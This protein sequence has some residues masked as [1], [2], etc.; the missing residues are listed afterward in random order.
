MIHAQVGGGLLLAA[1]IISTFATGLG[2]WSALRQDPTLAWV[3]RRGLYAATAAVAVSSVI[4]VLALVGHDFAIAFVAE[5]TDRATPVAF[6]VAAFYGGQEG[7]LLYWA[8][9]LSLLGSA[10]LASASAASLAVR[11]WAQVVISGILTFFLTVLVLVASPFA[12]FS[13][14]PPD[15]LGLNPLLRDQGMLIHPPFLLAGFASFAIPFSFAIAALLAREPGAGWIALTRKFALLAWGLQTVGLVLGMWWAYHVLGWGGYWG[16]DPVE[17]VALLPWLASTAYIH[18]AQIQE[19][20]GTLRAWNFGLVILSFL[21]AIFGTFVVRSGIIQSVHSFAV[22]SI[23]PWFLGF[24]IVCVAF[25]GLVLLIRL[26]ELRSAQPLEALV[27]REGAFLLNNLLFI[28]IAI[29]VLWGTLLP[30]ISTVGGGQQLV[31]GPPYY[32]RATGPL[33]LALLGLMAIGPMVPWQRADNRWLRS[34]RSQVL[35]AGLVATVVFAAGVR[36]PL[37]LLTAA[38]LGAAGATCL[39]EFYRAARFARR[40]SS[41]WLGSAW[42]LALRN[43]RRYAAYLAHFGL[44]LIAAGIAGSHFGQQERE[45]V[46]SPGQQVT[47]GN[48][49]LTYVKTSSVTLSD[50]DEYTA[51][52]QMGSET[53]RPQHLVY[54][55]GQSGTR[56][57]IRS[58]PLEDL[59]VV[60]SSVNSDG[61]AAFVLF[62]NPLVTWIWAGAAILIYGVWLGS[63]GA[64]PA[65]DVVEKRTLVSSELARAARL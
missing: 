1:L 51:E 65:V 57:A 22:S 23:G 47:I 27:S 49:T 19:R 26:P 53:L 34:L 24:L 48:Y 14:V 55:G 20:R 56:V 33:F 5:H 11:A 52:L 13:L 21:L 18:S 17:N 39:L 40:L 4:L 31:A 2:L 60:L 3:A 25:S 62:V 32:E 38:L 63:L 29:A 42:R 61:T 41:H 46:L 50:S 12:T 9:V 6:L 45:V 8:L 15:G 10:A 43:R 59:Y 30:L 28:T 37:Q 54:G 36:S 35:A 16:W 7:S 44:V 64:R 58:T